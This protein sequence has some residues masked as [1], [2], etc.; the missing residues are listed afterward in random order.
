M[1]PVCGVSMQVPGDALS[2]SVQLK[3][4][5]AL[6]CEWRQFREH[7]YKDHKLVGHAICFVG[8]LDGRAVAFTAICHQGTNM[9]FLF[10]RA[11]WQEQFKKIG[12]P[13]EWAQRTLMREHRTVVLPDSQGQGL[14]SLMADAVASVV[15][16][17]GYAFMSTTAHPTY[18]GYRD[19]SPLWA[20][21][22]TSKRDRQ[23]RPTTFSHVWIGATA[24]SMDGY[25]GRVDLRQMSDC[26]VLPST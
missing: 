24:T 26:K 6:P 17:L 19:R 2:P 4:R 14:G 18:G 15:E 16:R 13:L 1:S 7:H 25:E 23:G 9:T 11:T 10:P 3:I 5:R 8:E 22:P 12:V 20:T 21:L